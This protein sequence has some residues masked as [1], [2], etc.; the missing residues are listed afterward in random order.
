MK[1]M[2][3]VKKSYLTVIFFAAFLT[4]SI[5]PYQRGLAFADVTWDLN[6]YESG[7]GAILI[8]PILENYPDQ[9]VVR[10]EADPDPDHH[11]LYWDLGWDPIL[12]RPIVSYDKIIFVTMDEH[13]TI[14][15]YF[16]ENYKLTIYKTGLG[17][18]SI[19]PAQDLYEPGTE[20]DLVAI[21]GPQYRFA[22]WYLGWDPVTGEPITSDQEAIAITMD[23][24]RSITASFLLNTYT[25]NSSSGLNGTI[26]PFG[27]VSVLEGE[28][29]T[30]DMLPDEGH[31]ILEVWVDGNPVGPVPQFIFSDVTD[32]HEIYVEFDINTYPVTV[33]F[34]EGGIIDPYE[35]VLVVWSA[36]Q[37]FDMIPNEGYHVKNVIVDGDIK[38]PLD[39]YEFTDVREP[40]TIE[41]VFEINKYIISADA[42]PHGTISPIGEHEVEWGSDPTFNMI[43]DEGYHVKN[44][45]IDGLPQGPADYYEFTHVTGPH[46]IYVEF[47]INKYNI[48]AEAEPNGRIDP[49]GAFIMDWGSSR[50]FD[51]IPDEG[52][53]VDNVLI[54]GLSQGPLTTVD[55][56]NI[57]EDYHIE[58]SF[59]INVYTIFV[60]SNEGGVV[61]PG[62][63]VIVTHGSS[64]GFTITP[65][66]GY[67]IEEVT[68]DG[69]PKGPITSFAFDDVI[70]DHSIDVEFKI[71]TYTITVIANALGTVTPGTIE[72]DH[73]SSQEFTM[74][75]IEGHH[76]DDVLVDGFSQGK[77]TSYTFEDVTED[78]TLE[79]V[80][81]IDIYYLIAAV[82][83]PGG[84]IE[85]SGNVEVAHGTNKR[86]DILPNTGY[87]IVDVVVDTVSQGPIPSYTFEYITSGHDISATFAIDQ[88]TITS[89]SGP[90]G[91]ISQEGVITKD[92]GSSLS[93]TIT[94][95]IG[96]HVEDVVVDT[97]SKGPITSYEFTDI[98]E[99]HDISATFAIDEFTITSSSNDGGMIDSEGDIIVT[100]GSNKVFNIIH[101]TG[102]HIVDVVVDTVSKGPITSHI[103]EDIREDHQI[104]AEF[105]IDE[106]K[107]TSSSGPNGNISQE[108][109]ITVDYGSTL[110]LTM[111]PDTGY[112]VADVLVDTESQGPIPSYIF[113]DITVAHQIYATF[114]INEH[115]ITAQAGSGGTITPDGIVGVNEGDS[116][117]F[118]IE[119]FTGYHIVDVVVDTV[120]KGP[121]TS[122]EFTDITENHDISATF[123]IDEFKITSS[124]GP[125]GSISEEGVITVDYGSTRE[126]QI[127]PDARYH[128]VDVVVDT[129]SKGPIPSHKFEYITSQHQISATFAMNAYTITA[130]R[131]EGG[132]ITPFGEIP[133]NE[134]DSVT[135]EIEPDDGYFIEYVKVDGVSE[136]AITSYP[137]E[138]ITED[139]EIEA[140]FATYKYALNINAENGNVIKA[141]DTELY[142]W[143]TTVMLNAVGD[144]GFHFVEWSGDITG[145]ENPA[146]IT[147]Y[148]NKD[149]TAHFSDDT[150]LPTIIL[151]NDQLDG[152]T[153]FKSPLTITGTIRDD[154]GIT[155]AEINGG[156]FDEF[157]ED[158]S[159]SHDIDLLE[160]ENTI[161][162][163]AQDA[164]GNEAELK[165]TVN[166]FTLFIT[167]SLPEGPAVHTVPLDVRFTANTSAERKIVFYEWD[168]DGKGVYD[169]RSNYS[170]MAGFTFMGAGSY[171]ITLRVSDDER[172]I[173]SVVFPIHV[174]ADTSRSPYITETSADTLT[175]MAPLQVAFDGKAAD[176]DGTLARYEWDFDGDGVYD[177]MSKVSP[178]VVKTYGAAG[179]YAATLRVTDDDGY[180][181]TR[182]LLI[183]V[184]ANPSAPAS[185]APKATLV[186]DVE[187]PLPNQPL[188]LTA[189]KMSDSIRRYEWDFDGDNVFDNVSET[190][191]IQHTYHRAGRYK[192][193]VRLVYSDSFSEDASLDIRVIDEP[194]PITG[195]GDIT[196]TT[197]TVPCPV[198][199]LEKIGAVS[200]IKE[201][202]IDF[203]GDGNIDLKQTTLD[204]VIHEYTDA[205]IYRAKVIMVQNGGWEETVVVPVEATRSESNNVF[206]LT[207]KDGQSL[208]GA[209]VTIFA[210]VN[211]RLRRNIKSIGFQYRVKD[212]G[213]WSDI[214]EPKTHRPYATQWDTT[215]LDNVEHELRSVVTRVDGAVFN[216]P[217]TT[218]LIDNDGSDQDIKESL[219]AAGIHNKEQKVLSAGTNEI[220]IY[221]GTEVMLPPVDIPV[222]TDQLLIKI[223]PQD[224]VADPLS[225]SNPNKPNKEPVGAYRDITLLGGN[226]NFTKDV[227]ISIPYNDDELNGV[228]E[229]TL[230]IY[231]YN[232]TD[233]VWEEA[234]D[235]LVYPDENIVTA[236]TN[237]FSI[238]GIGG[239]GDGG[240]DDP[241]E[242]NPGVASVGSGG[243]SSGGGGGGSRCF[244]ATAAYGTS[245]A[246]EIYL[247]RRLRDE[248]LLK[249]RIG[250]RFIK[251]YY[252]HSPPIAEYISA[253]P[254]LR[255]I[256]RSMLK[257][258]VW[259]AKRLLVQKGA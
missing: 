70:E 191:D 208:S 112:H 207:P 201:Y 231:Y 168:F 256:V 50:S 121:I 171:P 149:I 18:V 223:L 162:I 75:A 239:V 8:D 158:G 105:A 249:N 164:G 130:K 211:P 192:A 108:G 199:F 118:T 196:K 188:N 206:T 41:A 34:N 195:P 154:E 166:L 214:G 257:P 183:E 242:P 11:F 103:F 185:A 97:V 44:I 227:D 167:A 17:D 71:H 52:Y 14:G 177:S 31:H 225:E 94:P 89:S 22:M 56:V 87:H 6:T 62:E 212:A 180:T 160:Y 107:I 155:V 73:G 184:L 189:E 48:T 111:E 237:H 46:E 245:T 241:G 254:R 102:Y 110:E 146:R 72:V 232:E 47:E 5:I 122:Y 205:G 222:S 60:N 10:L 251:A 226:N 198:D 135:F 39:Y 141:P 246:H 80:F 156:E 217:L 29:E 99:N 174:Q 106:F 9:T 69:D 113:E 175:G 77:I 137:F 40:H 216:S 15:A 37:R 35:D 123:A 58:A 238:Y 95:D 253:R 213:N 203:D 12:M 109:V 3:V 68:V 49:A 236:R 240:G 252:R 4:L 54:N 178:R 147:M 19:D 165:L 120:S 170:N 133:A 218:V 258:I 197:Q 157:N 38:G 210:K 250:R 78:H 144:E 84:R 7:N 32:D 51:I 90:N 33:I 30:F 176:I 163:T 115:T 67:Y 131:N 76:V 219:D 65:N 187:S 200:G 63:D 128:I 159:F 234:F 139:H 59:A 190:K 114:A 79:V 126:F 235:S 230:R 243:G 24:D 150:T 255:Q 42:G 101:D 55:L 13:K 43:P 134:G 220:A 25:I 169:H 61:D 1:T 127:I 244:I 224:G 138:N 64:Q 91:S 104:S 173:F 221:D 186:S 93:L 161:K 204:G 129:E 136:G 152:S 194:P 140:R 233:G 119:P 179:T 145:K 28:G 36:N 82:T 92:Y 148:S 57:A 209:N 81:A 45:Y 27:E 172:N 116:K 53:H 151:E 83:G 20:V 182:D 229:K 100:W 202:H 74:E 2:G 125:N 248:H 228:D 143:G 153:V 98:T 85:P 142:D 117:E 247:L 132:T 21:P 23:S 193:S 181:A 26:D 86:F 66:T 16:F 88:F 96:Y 259:C 124:S 215:V